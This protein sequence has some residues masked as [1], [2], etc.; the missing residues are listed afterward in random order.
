MKIVQINTFPYKAT[1]SIMMGIHEMLLENGF[2]SYVVWGRGR[3]SENK[4]EIVIKDNIGTKFHGVYTRLADRTGFASWRATRKLISE[5]EMIK[6]DIVHLHNIHGYYLNIEMLF[7]HIKKK[8]IK[9]V[10]TLHDC[11]PMTGHCAYFDM[12]GCE[13]W[14]AGCRKCE[15]KSTYPASVFM[16][17]SAN[18]WR[19][20]RILFTGLDATIV[21][22]SNWLKHIVKESYLKG[23]P[24]ELIYNG[25]DLNTFKP[26]IKET[27]RRQYSSDGKPIVLGVASEWTERKGLK[28]F[29]YLAK[30]KSKY[31]FVV[32]GLNADQMKQ[33]PNG[34]KGI[35]RTNNIQELV[36]LYSITD[37]FFNPTYEDNFPTTNIEALA[38]G[39][40]IIT[41]NTGGSHEVITHAEQEGIV[42]IGKVVYK[43][44]DFDK[45]M[46]QVEKAIEETI[47]TSIR[48]NCRKVAEQYDR[49]KRLSEYLKLY[50]DLLKGERL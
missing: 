30:K 24:V 38:C 18:N 42:G 12:I 16:D 9:V 25:I 34:I 29:I 20:K 2:D 44:I 8:K 28:D 41:Y 27:I 50:Q 19:R 40:P 22:P 4:R 1:G 33:I 3:D 32:V 23:Y 10:W 15:Q 6:P 46:L 36:E 31:Q 49:N 45:Q 17:N 7:T 21:T 47:K 48:D 13:K 39:T 11:W 35:Q 14:K 26:T 5:L 37:V 43:D